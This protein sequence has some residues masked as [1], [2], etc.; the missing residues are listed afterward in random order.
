MRLLDRYLLRELIVPLFFCLV[1]FLIFWTAFDL[2][3][4]LD[5]YRLLGIR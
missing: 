4:D 3:S 5:E 2:Y 1:G